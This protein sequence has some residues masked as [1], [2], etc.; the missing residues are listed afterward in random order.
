MAQDDDDDHKRESAMSLFGA[1]TPLIDT[2]LIQLYVIPQVIS[3]ADD[4]SGNVRKE[5]A[6]QLSNISQKVSKEINQ[7]LEEIPLV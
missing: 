7:C 6:N 3:F 4:H 1:L 5:V 2:D